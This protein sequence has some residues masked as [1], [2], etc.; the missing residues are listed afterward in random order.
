MNHRYSAQ[1]YEREK[2]S[3]Q[4]PMKQ[5]WY[6]RKSTYVLALL[7]VVAVII[8]GDLFSISSTG[9]QWDTQLRA[10]YNICWQDLSQYYTNGENSL[11]IANTNADQLKSIL[12]AVAA[13]RYGTGVNL[14]NPNNVV[15]TQLAAAYPDLHSASDAYNAARDILVGDFN[16][17]AEEN[18]KMYGMLSAYDDWREGNLLN[19]NFI[20][21]EGFPSDLLVANDG[22]QDLKG[23]KAEAQMWKVIADPSVAQSYK[24]GS[25]SPIAFPTP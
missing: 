18:K 7:A 17:Y 20:A 2:I 14:Q 1:A 3:P 24:N 23:A 16:N 6:L 9:T 12:T 19:R 11:K 21:W 4:P 5:S 13:G 15:Y 10:E 25:L 8:L 22:T